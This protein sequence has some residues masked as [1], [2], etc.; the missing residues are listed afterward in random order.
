MHASYSSLGKD[1]KATFDDLLKN[2]KSQQEEAD[3]LRSKLSESGNALMQA[4]AK[5]EKRL[6]AVIESEK[7]RGLEDRTNLIS[8]MKSLVQQF[9]ETQEKRLDSKMHEVKVDLAQSNETFGES[10]QSFNSSMDAWVARGEEL[11]TD[12]VKSREKVKSKIKLDWT[13]SFDSR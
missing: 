3:E 13:V 4:N 1:F 10:Q 2:F 11:N 6:Q 7:V 9:G 8:Q 5:S 12:I